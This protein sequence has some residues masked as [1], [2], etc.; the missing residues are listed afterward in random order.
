[1]L[2]LRCSQGG[3]RRPRMERPDRRDLVGHGFVDQNLRFLD[4]VG[5]IDPRGQ[6]AID[7]HFDHP[8]QPGTVPREKQ[9]ARRVITAAREFK[10][11]LR[12]VFRCCH[13]LKLLRLTPEN[14]EKGDSLFGAIRVIQAE[15]LMGIIL[16]SLADYELERSE[17]HGTEI[18]LFHPGKLGS[19]VIQP[20]NLIEEPTAFETD[21]EAI[22][23]VL[24]DLPGWT[25][26]NVDNAVT[27]E[28]GLIIEANPG[29]SVRYY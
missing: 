2:D 18:C 4:H 15:M 25:C 7:A 8:F 21:A 27:S 14:D 19:F 22:F 20:N 5:R 9:L 24:R 16:A 17:A 1:M 29:R 10:Q 23:R 11:S 28:L 6:T 13:R 26:V 3:F 12:R